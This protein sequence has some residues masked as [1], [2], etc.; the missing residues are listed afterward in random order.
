[1]HKR[2]REVA[3]GED[4]SDSASNTTKTQ[5]GDDSEG[6]QYNS[7]S[8][9]WKKQLA[10]GAWYEKAEKYWETSEVSVD[11]V[12]GGF[13]NLDGP[14]IVHSSQFLQSLFDSRPNMGRQRAMD[15][16]AGIGRV[17]KHLLAN[18]FKKIDLVESNARLLYAAPEFV[19]LPCLGA[20]FKQGLQDIVPKVGF[21]DCIWVQ[22]VVIYLTDNDFVLFLKRCLAGLREGGVIV[23][24]ENVCVDMQFHVD[25]AD[26]SLTRSEGYL[27]DIFKR[28][29]LQ[30]LVKSLQTDWPED[31]FPVYTYALCGAVSAES[32]ASESL[33]EPSL[34][35]SSD[36]PSQAAEPSVRAIGLA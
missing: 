10:D 36:A 12:L 17:V 28:A 25:C 13:E 9:M 11:G 34:I 18:F 1:M 14:D 23:I 8:E 26:S 6:Q 35:T 4:M 27:E 5:K 31:M 29:G 30:I 20:L 16:G 21:Y 24:K 22:W 33:S 3:K 32:S 19:N 7:T 15:C 2:S